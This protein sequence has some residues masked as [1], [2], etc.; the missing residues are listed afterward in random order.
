MA[1]CLSCQQELEAEAGGL[2]ENCRSKGPALRVKRPFG[3]GPERVV[4]P[5][6]ND[7]MLAPL[8]ESTAA[9]EEENL[10]PV[11]TEEELASVETDPVVLEEKVAPVVVVEELPP[12]VVVEDVPT[13]MAI[14]E[15]VPTPMVVAEDVP[16]PMAIVEDVPTPMAIAE[17][18]PTPMAI[19]EDV[20]AP[21]AIAEDIPTPMVVAE[22]V[23]TPMAIVE[24]I[25]TPM[26]VAED[27]PTP[28]TI[29]EDIPTP[30]AI[31]VEEEPAVAMED[32][33]V[34]VVEDEKTATAPDVLESFPSEPGFETILASP[35]P[36][37]TI[38]PTTANTITTN[39]EEETPSFLQEEDDPQD[40]PALSPN[41]KQ[42]HYFQE[43]PIKVYSDPHHYDQISSLRFSS[44]NQ[45]SLE[46]SVITEL[47]DLT[48]GNPAIDD[49]IALNALTNA[50]A[51]ELIFL[52]QS[53]VQDDEEE[54]ITKTWVYPP[55]YTGTS[56]VLVSIVD[57]DNVWTF[58][59]HNITERMAHSREGGCQR[60]LFTRSGSL[61]PHIA[62]DL[63]LVYVLLI[64][65]ES[66]LSYNT[67]YRARVRAFVEEMFHTRQNSEFLLVGIESTLESKRVYLELMAQDVSITNHM[68]GKILTVNISDPHVSPNMEGQWGQLVTRIGQCIVQAAQSRLPALEHAMV[69]SS[70]QLDSAPTEHFNFLL[71]FTKV[72]QLAFALL[73]IDRYEQ[74]GALYRKL[75]TEFSNL[76]R[77]GG[78]LQ[79]ERMLTRQKMDCTLLLF[80]QSK[81]KQQ[82]DCIR[83]ALSPSRIFEVNRLPFTEMILGCSITSLQLEFYLFTRIVLCDLAQNDSIQAVITGL[84][85]L[86]HAQVELKH[87][88]VGEDTL[89][90][91]W[92]LST[93]LEIVGAGH[94]CANEFPLAPLVRVRLCY[95]Q[96][97]ILERAVACL[98]RISKRECAGQGRAFCPQLALETKCNLNVV[99][100]PPSLQLA[101][102]S[103]NKAFA[104]I[105]LRL[106]EASAAHYIAGGRFRSAAALTY[107]RAIMLSNIDAMTSQSLL[108]DAARWWSGKRRIEVGELGLVSEIDSDL[109]EDGG[110]LRHDHWPSLL[111]E[112]TPQEL[113]LFE[114]RH[115]FPRA[116]RLVLARQMVKGELSKLLFP[117]LVRLVKNKLELDWA[118]PEVLEMFDDHRV[119]VEK[120]VLVCQR[121]FSLEKIN[122]MRDHTLPADTLAIQLEQNPSAGEYLP[123]KAFVWILGKAYECHVEIQSKETILVPPEPFPLRLEL[124]GSSFL[125]CGVRTAEQLEAND[126][127]Q[128]INLLCTALDP[129]FDHVLTMPIHAQLLHASPGLVFVQDTFTFS[130]KHT[131]KLLIRQKLVSELAKTGKFTVALFIPEMPIYEQEFELPFHFPVHVGHSVCFV[132]QADEAALCFQ[133]GCDSTTTIR[134]EAEACIMHSFSL[135]SIRP[136]MVRITPPSELFPV[137]IAPNRPIMHLG[138]ILQQLGEIVPPQFAITALFFLNAQV[139]LE[140]DG[141]ARRIVLNWSVPLLIERGDVVTITSWNQDVG[142]I[143]TVPPLVSVRLMDREEDLSGVEDSAIVIEL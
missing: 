93:S 140:V 9:A 52:P 127:I 24:D 43:S 37:L 135:T 4:L 31:V 119:Q 67:T 136:G 25:P 30:M 133:F 3:E 122:L 2:C 132:Q 11:A 13:P 139:E 102:F 95:V 108:N 101:L 59:E 61:K 39:N 8:E 27:I 87:E 46:D 32:A 134:K 23:P 142:L 72:E 6:R 105:Y 41:N 7:V 68:G 70:A 84:D 118:L 137:I 14:V 10:P 62:P 58:M 143:N 130:R 99:G 90:D 69:Q 1:A 86:R 75:Q 88:Y 36:I 141:G 117:V 71:Y 35:S 28:M 80:P 131:F 66:V 40:I 98:D 22:D 50:V 44:F 60:C 125:S 26:V 78:N 85:F 34:T 57:P 82:E 12:V 100:L 126:C 120:T 114:I 48:D 45:S 18:V 106:L 54:S 83:A 91:L 5:L 33:P 107:R 92:L 21:M 89:I 124:Q 79:V 123:V 17:D 110:G 73:Q 104:N 115:V 103:T 65:C 109:E 113:S 29:V 81:S 51:R 138:F 76:K 63:P 47:N 56:S 74:A 116:R 49:P 129:K 16:T 53:I 64:R 111:A 42:L 97:V 121:A 77:M 94:A 96:A 38:S 112:S 19:A 20:P 55:A 15:D 128:E